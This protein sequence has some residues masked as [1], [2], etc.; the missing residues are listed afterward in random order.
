M[1]FLVKILFSSFALGEHLDMYSISGIYDK[2]LKEAAEFELP[3]VLRLINQLV[4]RNLALAS[5][6]QPAVGLS[7]C[8]NTQRRKRSS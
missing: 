3:F 4:C 5:N 8:T 1:R 2:F 7:A 6:R